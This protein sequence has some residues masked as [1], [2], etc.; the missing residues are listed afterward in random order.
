V[1]I[2]AGADDA[3]SGGKESFGPLPSDASNAN[4]HVAF[5]IDGEAERGT[6]EVG[7]LEEVTILA[8]FIEPAFFAREAADCRSGMKPGDE[9][10]GTCVL[11]EGDGEFGLEMSE[12]SGLTKATRASGN[13]AEAGELGFEVARY[14]FVFLD[15]FDV[16]H[17]RFVSA[18]FSCACE[19]HGFDLGTIRMEEEFRGGSCESVIAID[20]SV[21]PK[22]GRCGEDT[23]EETF[24][25]AFDQH[26]MFGENGDH[27]FEAAGDDF[28][29]N[30]AECHFEVFG[31][32]MSPVD[33]RPGEVAPG[34]GVVGSE[35][36]DASGA[37]PRNG[38]LEVEVI[39]VESGPIDWSFR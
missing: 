20:A 23:V 30:A 11:E 13:L 2:G 36:N 9:G 26:A 37:L 33:S 16:L 22:A 29:A 28:F 34:R 5:A 10:G 21:T 14:E 3:T 12:G 6:K 35:R 15:F 17:E 27:F 4:D 1:V 19:G 18:G 25:A 8:Q 31:G 7:D 24:P 39:P 32:G 38:V